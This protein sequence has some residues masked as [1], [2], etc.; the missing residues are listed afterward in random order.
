[1]EFKTEVIFLVPAYFIGFFILLFVLIRF[2]IG[3]Y[4]EDKCPGCESNKSIERRRS[5]LINGMIPFV[6]SRKFF[7]FKCKKC[8]Y[9]RSLFK[10]N[11]KGKS[12]NKTN[13]E[14]ALTIAN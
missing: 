3:F 2:F 1:M 4:F 8:F 6:D 11:I 12:N 9:K 10:E 13:K 14:N 5:S 7:C